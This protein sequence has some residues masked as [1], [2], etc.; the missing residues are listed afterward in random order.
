MSRYR[1]TPPRSIAYRLK[2]YQSMSKRR[3]GRSVQLEADVSRSTVRTT[4]R[5]QYRRCRPRRRRQGIW[6]QSVTA[7]LHGK[8]VVAT[9]LKQR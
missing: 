6:T 3:P 9:L 1:S 2:P 8:T 4:D 5:L 7:S